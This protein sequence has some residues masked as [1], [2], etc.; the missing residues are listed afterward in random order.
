MSPVYLHF[1][2]LVHVYKKHFSTHQ[3]DVFIV[4]QIY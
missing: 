4:I 1:K 2:M 3:A